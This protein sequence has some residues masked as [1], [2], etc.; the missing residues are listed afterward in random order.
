MAIL[1]GGRCSGLSGRGFLRRRA[2]CRVCCVVL[3]WFHP[4]ALQRSMVNASFPLLGL[5]SWHLEGFVDP[6][7]S[8]FGVLM[9]GAASDLSGRG[10]LMPGLL[11]MSSPPLPSVT[12]WRPGLTRA[13]RRRPLCLD[14]F[15][16]VVSRGS[17]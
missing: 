15:W 10:F 4:E 3:V 6:G 1:G 17:R 8:G 7:L 14:G 9:P 16:L 2:P 12:S 11:F 5:A 13:C